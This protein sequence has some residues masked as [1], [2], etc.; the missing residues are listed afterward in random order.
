MKLLLTLLAT[1]ATTVLAQ[2]DPSC[3][4]NYIVEACL[5]TENGKLA[6]CGTN[7]YVCRCAAFAN[8]LT[9][10]N[11]CPNDP[12]RCMSSPS[13]ALFPEAVKLTPPKSTRQ[14]N[15]PSSAAT[16]RSS[17]RAPPRRFPRR[18]P[19]FPLPRLALAAAAP[20]PAVAAAPGRRPTRPRRRPR[21]VGPR[22]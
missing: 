11:N 3:Q 6:A 16:P 2:G 21:R 14:A 22:A 7:D 17:P 4:A 1:A 10:Y 12:R 15:R 13:H 5:G 8:I 18:R 19:T 9:C 20:D